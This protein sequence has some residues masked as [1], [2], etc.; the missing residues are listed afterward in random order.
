MRFQLRMR[1]G[2]WAVLVVMVDGVPVP[3]Y[4]QQAVFENLVQSRAQQIC[5]AANTGLFTRLLAAVAEERRA[6]ENDAKGR[7]GGTRRDAGGLGG[8]R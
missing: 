6:R 8:V 3:E 1:N 4:R 7:N 5:D 2:K